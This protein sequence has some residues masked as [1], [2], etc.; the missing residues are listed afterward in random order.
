LPSKVAQHLDGA[1]QAAAATEAEGDPYELLNFWRKQV[2]LL[3]G[4]S[5]RP[6]P[7]EPQGQIKLLRKIYAYTGQGISNVLD[8]ERVSYKGGTCVARRLKRDELARLVGSDRPSA[9][10]AEAAVGKINEELG[11][12]ECVCF[13]IYAVKDRQRAVGWYFVGNTID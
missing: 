1:R 5:R 3:E 6:L 12:G 7:R 8:V 11:R 4:V 2:A 9:A 13:P 10:Q